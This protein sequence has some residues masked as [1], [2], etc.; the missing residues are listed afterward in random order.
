M[1]DEQSIS[2]NGVVKRIIF[3]GDNFVIACLNDDT[4]ICGNCS[5]DAKSLVGEEVSIS[6]KWVRHQKYGKQFEFY[7]LNISQNEMVFFLNKIVKGISKANA[8][9][10]IDTYGD[11]LADILDK[12]NPKE[13]LKLKGIKEK[14]LLMIKK[15]WDEHKH[16]KEIGSFLA[17]F[18][19]SKFLISKI[20]EF[21]SQANLKIDDIKQNPYVLMNIRG[22][23]FKKADEI[24]LAIGIEEFSDFRIKACM[25]YVLKYISENEGSSS[26]SKNLLYAKLDE[27]LKCEKNSKDSIYEQSLIKAIANSEIYETSYERYALAMYYNCESRILEFFKHRSSKISG[28]K[29]VNDIE[30]YIQNKEKQLGFLLDED[31]KKAVRLINDGVNVLLLI[32]Y[33]GT[34]KST[35]S[36]ALLDLLH[37]KFDYDDICVIALSGIASQRINE[38]TGYR[39]FTIQSLLIANEQSETFDYKVIL[40]DEASMVNS[41]MFHQ[42]ISKLSDDCVFIIVGDD[43]QLPA[44]GAGDVLRDCIKHDLAPMCKLETLHRQS[45]KQ[46]IAVI[47]NDIRKGKVPDCLGDES[48]QYEDFNFVDVSIKNYYKVK[49]TIDPNE[50]K[51]LSHKNNEDI[52]EHILKISKEYK[53]KVDE[54]LKNK[55][56]DKALRSFQVITPIKMGILGSENLNKQLQKVFNDRKNYHSA[57]TYKYGVSD[58]V[59]HIKNENMQCQSID[60][61]KNGSEKFS[62]KRIFNGQLGL[63]VKIN[64]TDEQCIV[65]YPNDNLIVYYHFD[66]LDILLSLAYALTIHKT[67]GMEYDCAL[68]PMS[69][70]HYIMH[71]TKLLYTAIT[72]AKKMCYVVGEVEAFKSG[73]KKLNTT[74]RHTIIDDLLSKKD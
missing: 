19:V 51:A 49:N 30:K 31:Q 69:F 62:K 16:L 72:R 9:I 6:G 1:Q 37:E 57:R 52:L 15:S 4:I 28:S 13:L 27:E 70:S 29:I 61:Y 24:A 14:K 48:A 26:V 44:I 8:N 45:E 73:C 3:S 12:P 66:D 74:I 38:T 58:K 34:G 39:A 50:F 42:I 23:A 7:E 10:L 36:K 33:A 22:V 25:N 2:L 21:I 55:K 63:I 71:N 56:I 20:Y 47:A 32:G 46:A 53:Q 60:E 41:V 5:L 54:N 18:G 68:L 35:S 40:L 43:G 64:A 65:L 67:Q 59:I 17:K 11:K